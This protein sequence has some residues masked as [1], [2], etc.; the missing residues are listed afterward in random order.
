MGDIDLAY[1][2]STDLSV[3]YSISK[4]AVNMVNA[5]YAVALKEEGFIFLAISPGLVDTA[6]GRPFL[7]L[8]SYRGIHQGAT[9]YSGANGGAV[10]GYH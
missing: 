4:S 1:K 6:T 8:W 7:P 2:S 9:L 3:P 5:K 10:E